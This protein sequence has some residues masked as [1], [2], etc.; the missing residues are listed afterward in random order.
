MEISLPYSKGFPTLNYKIEYYVLKTSIANTF[1]S[2]EDNQNSNEH[3]GTIWAEIK[4]NN[5]KT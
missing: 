1:K 5:F 3:D 4:K 2:K